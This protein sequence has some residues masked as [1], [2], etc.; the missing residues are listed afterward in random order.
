MLVASKP[1]QNCQW[2][3]VLRQ[4]RSTTM[5][6]HKMRHCIS[7]RTLARNQGLGIFSTDVAKYSEIL[8]T[9]HEYSATTDDC[10]LGDF[11]DIFYDFQRAIFVLYLKIRV[12]GGTRFN[13][14]MGSNGPTQLDGFASL[15][16]VIPSPEK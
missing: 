5:S 7:P 15:N 8:L 13:G 16:R 14:P 6:V 4:E 1:K 2:D 10:S 11:N 12:I 3:L 9:P